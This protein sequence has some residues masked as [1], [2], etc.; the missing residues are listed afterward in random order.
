MSWRSPGV[1]AVPCRGVSR[2]VFFVG[3]LLLALP[4]AALGLAPAAA[5]AHP[6]HAAAP[7]LGKTASPAVDLTLHYRSMLSGIFAPNF[8]ATDAAGNL[9]VAD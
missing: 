9:Y 3:V 6:A 1:L 7:S 2:S 8:L 4:L 5:F